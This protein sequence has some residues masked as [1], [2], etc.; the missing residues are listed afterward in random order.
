[1]R[2][3]RENSGGLPREFL[4]GAYAQE[5]NCISLSSCGRCRSDQTRSGSE[6][7]RQPADSTPAAAASNI[8]S[9][10]IIN[11][12]MQQMVGYNPE[13]TWRVA[14]VRPTVVPGLTEVVVVI[15]DSKGS[16]SNKFYVSADRQT[17]GHGRHHPLRREA[18]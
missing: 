15:T 10:E 11:A 16:N 3:T 13:V 12:F 4:K 17:R 9:E 1:L 2:G 6:A 7:C 8:P 18:I 5:R 14:E